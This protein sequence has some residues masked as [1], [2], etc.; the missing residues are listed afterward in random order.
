MKYLL[1]A[2]LTFYPRGGVQ[3]LVLRA[4][5]IQECKD[6]VDR[7]LLPGNNDTIGGMPTSSAGEVDFYIVEH[8]SMKQVLSGNVDYFRP[9]GRNPT[10]TVEWEPRT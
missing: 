2:S 10:E 9:P 7:T 1:F 4:E 3:D 5:S 6:W 8:D